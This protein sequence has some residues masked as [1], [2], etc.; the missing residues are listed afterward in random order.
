MGHACPPDAMLGF[1][2]LWDM[3][4]E[5]ECLKKFKGF[6]FWSEME[7]Y[8]WSNALVSLVDEATK[9]NWMFLTK[10]MY[11]PHCYS[12]KAAW[13]M[14]HFPRHVKKLCIIGSSKA[15][16]AR[17][18]EDV[19]IDDHIENINEWRQAGGTAYHWKEIGENAPKEIYEN[20]LKDVAEIL[21]NLP[22]SQPF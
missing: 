10:P 4:G 5:E 14:H 12:G 13:I 1:S 3:H 19:L 9:G 7:A 8:P 17:N 16:M 18:F 15:N 11:D 2:C 22:D 21:I 6:Q 20:R